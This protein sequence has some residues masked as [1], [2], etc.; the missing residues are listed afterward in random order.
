MTPRRRRGG[1]SKRA[2]LARP[3]RWRSVS[4]TPRGGSKKSRSTADAADRKRFVRREK[5]NDRR[6]A[7]DCTLHTEQVFEA[8]MTIRF[9]ARIVQ[10][11]YWFQVWNPPYI[12]YSHTIVPLKNLWNSHFSRDEPNLDFCYNFKSS[13]FHV[14][15][16]SRALS[17]VFRNP[18]FPGTLNACCEERQAAYTQAFPTV[19]ER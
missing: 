13:G 17:P 11:V 18:C 8:L 1:Q 6:N 12:G 15:T 9:N 7:S 4:G 19:V 10:R 14:F 5:Q 2:E 3:S 16:H